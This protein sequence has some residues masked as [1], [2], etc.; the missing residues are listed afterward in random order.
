MKEIQQQIKNCEIKANRQVA[1]CHIPKCLSCSETK[2]K[3]RSHKQHRGSI[4]Q[5]YN[6]PGSNTLIDHVDE[7]NVPGYTWQH[8]GRP[9]L[10]KYKYFMLFV[11]HKTRLVHPS[12]QESKTASE[13]CHSKCNTQQSVPMVWDPKTKLVSP[14][15]HVMFN[16]NLDTEQ[17]DT[18]DRLL[19]TNRYTYDDPF[20]NTHTYLLSHGGVDIHPENLTPTIE[21][22]KASFTMTPTHDEHHSEIQNNTSTENTPK[23]TFI[24]SMQDLVILHANNIF[25]QNSKD[26]FKAYKHLHGIDKKIHYIPK[27]PKQKAQEM[28][29]SDLHN[30]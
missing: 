13:A 17:A 2:G 3:K 25:Q 14:Q 24:F 18:M 7:D 22:C 29:L 10:K 30:E 6:H 28:E 27:S 1:T 4:T 9:T 21:T 19:K 8:K 15:F 23:N 12:F 20:G 11:D 26:D 16:D 5:N